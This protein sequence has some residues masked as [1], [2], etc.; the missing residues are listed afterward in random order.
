MLLLENQTNRQVSIVLRT[1][2]YRGSLSGDEQILDLLDQRESL[3]ARG[4]VISEA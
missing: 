2:N 4:I 3:E 1:R